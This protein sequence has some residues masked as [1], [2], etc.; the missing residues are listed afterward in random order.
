MLQT[1]WNPQKGRRRNFRARTFGLSESMAMNR[2][3]RANVKN[4]FIKCAGDNIPIILLTMALF[5]SD[6]NCVEL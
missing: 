4:L 6:N 3:S 5:Y 1:I 2:T